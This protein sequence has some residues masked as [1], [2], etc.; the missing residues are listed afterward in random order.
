MLGCQQWRHAGRSSYLCNTNEFR[1]EKSERF[2]IK[3]QL[4]G[5]LNIFNNHDAVQ[6]KISFV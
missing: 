4:K 5:Y 3:E 1:L 2:Q 6:F